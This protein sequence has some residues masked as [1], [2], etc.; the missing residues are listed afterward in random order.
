GTWFSSFGQPKEQDPR[1]AQK[2][3]ESSR[4]TGHCPESQTGCPGAR[5][6]RSSMPGHAVVA[7]GPSRHR[8]TLQPGAW[9]ALSSGGAMKRLVQ[10]LI[11]LVLAVVACSGSELSTGGPP[12]FGTERGPCYADGTCN[13][14]LVCL[15]NTCV[16][17]GND[18]GALS[19]S[20]T[21]SGRPDARN[22]AG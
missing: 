11:V 14:G 16:N 10:V 8:S 19:D 22:D 3:L 6:P 20:S 7:N 4:S 13:A 17:P 5:H 15:S 9:D 2:A 12:P 18:G 21:D 1:R